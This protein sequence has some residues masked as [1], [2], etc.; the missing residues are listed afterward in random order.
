MLPDF[1]HKYWK[2]CFFFLLCS[3]DGLAVKQSSFHHKTQ[4]AFEIIAPFCNSIPHTEK[5]TEYYYNIWIEV[6]VWIHT[7]KRKEVKYEHEVHKGGRFCL[8]RICLGMKTKKKK[9]KVSGRSR[10]SL[11]G[12]HFY[13]TM[14]SKLCDVSGISL[15]WFSPLIILPVTAHP[16]FHSHPLFKLHLPPSLPVCCSLLS[17]KPQI[18]A[19]LVSFYFDLLVLIQ[20]Q[21]PLEKK[22]III[23]TD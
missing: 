8:L 13:N 3:R 1:M 17:Q 16:T 14:N 10:C 20:L 9:K 23:N 18:P 15:S 6:L 22:A 5:S 7:S 21:Q 4:E 19:T 2:S 12:N 11:L